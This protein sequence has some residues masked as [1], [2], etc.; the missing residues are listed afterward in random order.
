MYCDDIFITSWAVASVR[1][2]GKHSAYKKCKIVPN[3][4][5]DKSENGGGFECHGISFPCNCAIHECILNWKRKNH[6]MNTIR[7]KK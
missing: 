7:G 5:S 4:S 6:A 1:V 2:L 3:T